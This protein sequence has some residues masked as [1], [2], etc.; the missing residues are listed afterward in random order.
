MRTWILGLIA[1]ALVATS[2]IGAKND[3]GVTDAL[4]YLWITSMGRVEE[5]P[6][7]VAER[8]RLRYRVWDMLCFDLRDID[9]SGI[10]V[11]KIAKFKPNPFNPG[12]AGYYQGGDTVFVRDNLKG[13]AR[14]EVVAHEMSHYLDVMV[15]GT[16]VPG[17]AREICFSEK[18]AWAVSDAFWIRQGYSKT[19]P[20]IIGSSW[21][22]WYRHCTPFKAEMYP[23]G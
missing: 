3:T 15:L 1:A 7:E 19:H 13:A 18:R 10:P 2:G 4:D 17:P 5:T 14:D 6:L 23:N 12:I 21:A 11:P 9:C 8:Q 16:Q 20:K 22:D